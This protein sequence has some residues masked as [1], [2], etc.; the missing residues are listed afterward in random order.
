MEPIVARTLEF[1]VLTG[2]LFAPIEHFFG[3]RE[4]DRR[5]RLTDLLFATVG[6]MIGRAGL[7]FVIAVALAYLDRFAPERALIPYTTFGQVLEVVLG[8]FLIAFSGY[9]WHR[10]SHAVPWLWRMHSVHHSSESMDWL[11]GFRRHPLEVMLTTLVQNAPVVMLGI[12]LGAHIAV[13]ILLRVNTIFVHS[14]LHVNLGPLRYLIA[15]PDFHHRHHARHGEAKNF[16][17]IFPFLDY[18]FGT[19]TDEAADEFGVDEPMPT[20][21]TGL[22]LHP[23][24]PATPVATPASAGERPTR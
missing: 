4:N 10:L 7:V 11:A 2:L 8:L 15:T 17:S 9:V 3:A 18:A 12:P 5:G 13:I 6:E 19:G 20:S 22:M 1:A 21:F 16:S 14:N 23:F 24:V